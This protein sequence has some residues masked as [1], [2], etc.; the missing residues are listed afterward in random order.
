EADPDEEEEDGPGAGELA[1]ALPWD[2]EH[3]PL[4]FTRLP[5]E[6]TVRRSQEFYAFMEQRRTAVR[7]VSSCALRRDGAERGAHGALDVRGGVG[8]R[9]EAAH[10]RDRGGGGARQLHQA[11]GTPL[12]CGPAL[13]ALLG[14]PNSEKLTLL[15]PVGYPAADA[16]VPDLRRKPLEDILVEI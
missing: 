6:E 10:P 11:H 14:R 9:G 8:P 12:N 7:G 4:A 5:V 16:T 2:L 3:V 13:R 15:L 1:S